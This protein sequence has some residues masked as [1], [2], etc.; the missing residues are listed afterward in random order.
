MNQ[1]TVSSSN[2]EGIATTTS[3]GCSQSSV[4]LGSSFTT[5]A[6][7]E[8][9]QMASLNGYL[10]PTSEWNSFENTEFSKD[11]GALLSSSL[12][13]FGFPPS[14]SR[15]PT[16]IES[17]PSLLSSTP[18]STS[19]SGD[20]S[21]YFSLG[22]DFHSPLTPES[23]P[24]SDGSVKATSPSSFP[25]HAF[26][27]QY[28]LTSELSPPTEE[29]YTRNAFVSQASALSNFNSP[30]CPLLGN[31]N[32]PNDITE[33]SS[34]IPGPPT[35]SEQSFCLPTAEGNDQE[36]FDPSLLE[37]VNFPS[38]ET[39]SSSGK[40]HWSIFRLHYFKGLWNS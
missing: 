40:W 8:P 14:I 5:L 29:L 32:L 28:S 23:D 11:F 38:K 31:D 6:P 2:L 35:T 22:N 34:L 19:V 37:Q 15:T 39:S 1:T 36:D 20:S 10:P 9:S 25:F 12:L 24:S 7:L 3:A 30:F 33:P 17:I 18:L 4:P 21:C 26:N 16:P 27:P 13:E